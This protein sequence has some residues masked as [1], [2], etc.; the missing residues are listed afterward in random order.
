MLI[1]QV[2]ISRQAKR[3]LRKV[4]AYIVD[5]LLAWVQRVEKVGVSEVRLIRG[6]HDESLS[7]DRLGQ[8]SIRLSRSYRAIYAIKE[9]NRVKFVRIEEVNKHD[10]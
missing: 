3:D 5:K 8:R 7:G 10:Y 6:F 1:K 9:I 2:D 4:P